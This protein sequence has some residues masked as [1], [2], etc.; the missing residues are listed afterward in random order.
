ML[1]EKTSTCEKTLALVSEKLSL[2]DI[3]KNAE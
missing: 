2:A 3:A 1:K